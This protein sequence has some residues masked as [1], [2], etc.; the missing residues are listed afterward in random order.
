MATKNQ[1]Y[2]HTLLF[3]SL[4]SVERTVKHFAFILQTKNFQY[5]HVSVTVRRWEHRAVNLSIMPYYLIWLSKSMQWGKHYYL[6]FQV[7]KTEIQGKVKWLPQDHAHQK[8]SNFLSHKVAPN[9]PNLLMVLQK[10][11]LMHKNT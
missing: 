5:P 8:T 7:E 2:F 10:T 11:H 6:H 9:S 1:I 3:L 4:I